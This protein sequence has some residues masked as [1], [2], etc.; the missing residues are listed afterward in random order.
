M[1]K[2]EV[3]RALFEYNQW[4]NERLLDAAARVS[5]EELARERDGDVGSL[6]AILMHIIGS[7]IVG[8]GVWKIEPPAMAKVEPGRVVAALR[9][10]Y[11][12]VHKK[13]REFVGSLTDEQ[14]DEAMPLLNPQEGKW[15]T[16]ERPVWQVALS[17]GTHAMQHRGEAAMI[18]TE[19]GHSPGQIDYSYFCW[20]GREQ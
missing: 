18:L 11:A 8:L 5:E 15:R 14:L 13:L 6:Q 3:V 19:L 17:F 9:E 20:R 7:H 1:S 4:A 10:S 12:G 2:A 16:W